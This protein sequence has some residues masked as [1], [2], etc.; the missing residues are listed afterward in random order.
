[1]NSDKNRVYRTSIEDLKV[2]RIIFWIKIKCKK[3][4][5]IIRVFIAQL[6][7]KKQYYNTWKTG[8]IKNGSRVL[9]LIFICY[10]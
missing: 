9:G 1:M 4:G 7:I 2:G 10:M 3:Q 5:K 6:W 8:Y